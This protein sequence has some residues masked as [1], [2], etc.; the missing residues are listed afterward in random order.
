MS[1]QSVAKLFYG[2]KTA[3]CKWCLEEYIIHE[4]TAYNMEDYCDGECEF[5]SEEIDEDEE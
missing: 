5:L 4:S 2:N 1:S 3:I